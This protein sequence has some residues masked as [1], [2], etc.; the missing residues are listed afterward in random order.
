MNYEWISQEKEQH[1]TE[2]L[3]N[4]KIMMTHTFETEL[5]VLNV[6][7]LTILKIV[8][9]IL[10]NMILRKQLSFHKIYTRGEERF[11][12]VVI[13]SYILWYIFLSYLILPA[14]V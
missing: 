9:V 6:D 13:L 10:V 2:R 5:F 12:A 7:A 4:Q 14:R 11:V 8:N 3:L 1:A